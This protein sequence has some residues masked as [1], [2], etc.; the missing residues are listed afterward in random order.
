MTSWLQASGHLAKVRAS[1]LA[2]PAASACY[3]LAVW[4]LRERTPAREYLFLL[5]VPLAVALSIAPLVLNSLVRCRVCGVR[6]WGC[7]AARALPSHRRQRWIEELKA[8]PACG[9]DGHA[10]HESEMRWL[11]SGGA[12]E[13]PYWTTRRVMLAVLVIVLVG[14]GSL[15]F[16]TSYR[17]TLGRTNSA[18]GPTTR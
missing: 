14:G 7:K 12:P 1:R 9:D 13:A 15:Y 3:L 6:V 2:F 8:C 17:V 18:S 11:A 5:A 10:T 4:A 16:A